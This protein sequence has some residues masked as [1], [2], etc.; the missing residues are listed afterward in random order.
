MSFPRSTRI[1]VALWAAAGLAACALSLASMV[2][3]A[4]PTATAIVFAAV[5]GALMAASWIWPITLY[6]DG[7]S[8]GIV[9]DEGFL[10]LLVLLVPSAMTVLVFVV[11]TVCAQAIK[12]RPLVKSVF[13]VGQ[14]VTAAGLG[15]LAFT[16]AARC[17]GTDRLRQGRGRARRC[18]LLLRREHRRHGDDHGDA[19]HPVAPD[20][21][22]RNQGQVAR[23]LAAASAIAIP[24]RAAVG[25]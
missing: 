10:V 12:R 16:L 1:V 8:D 9:L 3:A 15:A 22:R 5:F 13:N 19:R 14:V 7:Q 6:I 25:Q 23:H 2:A 17:P 4:P 18:G 11:V 20:G 24:G 21:L